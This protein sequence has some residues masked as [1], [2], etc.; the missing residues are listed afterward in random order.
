MTAAYYQLE[1]IWAKATLAE[2]RKLIRIAKTKT[3]TNC[4][5]GE[6]GAAMHILRRTDYGA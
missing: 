5:W 3:P 6:Y 1:G 4:G 2:R